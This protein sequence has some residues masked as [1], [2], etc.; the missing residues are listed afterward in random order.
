MRRCLKLVWVLEDKRYNDDG[1]WSGKKVRVML[2]WALSSN[3]CPAIDKPTNGLSP[4]IMETTDLIIPGWRRSR[5]LLRTPCWLVRSHDWKGTSSVM[6]DCSYVHTKCQPS[7]MVKIPTFAQALQSEDLQQFLVRPRIY[8]DRGP[9]GS[10]AHITSDQYQ[11]Q[12]WRQEKEKSWKRT[13]C[14]NASFRF[15]LHLSSNVILLSYA[16]EQHA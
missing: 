5:L 10:S 4:W 8:P 9:V 16:M 3:R 1:W 12:S 6:Y 13:G 14:I 11:R 2:L 7:D 15:C